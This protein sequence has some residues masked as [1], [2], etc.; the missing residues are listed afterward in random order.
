MYHEKKEFTDAQIRDAD[1]VDIVGFLQ[2]QGEAVSKEYHEYKW[3]RHDSVK[4][5]PDKNI[6]CQHS[7]KKGGGMISFIMTF[8]EDLGLDCSTFPKAVRYLIGESLPD[9]PVRKHCSVPA[10]EQKR[11]FRLSVPCANND[12]V[13]SYLQTVRKISPDVLTPFLA[14]GDVYEECRNGYYNCVFVGRDPAGV[15]QSATWRATEGVCR[16]DFPGS[17]KRYGFSHITD[18]SDLFVFEAPIEVLSFATLFPAAMKHNL[19]SQGGCSNFGCTFQFL[20]DH[21]NIRRVF[22]GFNNDTDKKNNPGQSACDRLEQSLPAALTVYRVIPCQGD[23]NDLLRSVTSHAAT[24]KGSYTV[25]M[26]S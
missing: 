1:S 20:S 25:R 18:S 17:N 9:I 2:S 3:E 21:P 6:W 22:L 16:R 23:W 15:A 7:T 14:A 10:A 8:S 5:N 13:V 11:E 4:I 24:L 26:R 19:L 12:H